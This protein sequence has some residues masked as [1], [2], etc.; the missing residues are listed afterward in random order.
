M[1]RYRNGWWLEIKYWDERLTQREIADE[2]GISPRQIREYMDRF[3]IPT[4]EMRGED[5]PMHGRKRS[6]EAKQKI[7]NSLQGRSLSEETRQRISDSQTGTELSAEVR[8]RISESL[9]GVTRSAETR[10]KMS[11]STAGEDN[12][13]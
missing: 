1:K 3:D 11:E 8:K 13:N 9:E 4:R 5:H 12:P 7:S 6:D 2:C 10:R